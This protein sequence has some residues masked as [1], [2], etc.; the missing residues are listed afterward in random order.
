MIVRSPYPDVVIPVQPLTAFILA[1]AVDQG[2]LSSRID[3]ASGRALTYAQ[4]VADVRR[5]AIGLTERGLG[6]GDALAL[7][8]PNLPEYGYRTTIPW[9]F[10]LGKR[11]LHTSW[12]P[13]APC[14]ST[15]HPRAAFG[16]PC[17]RQVGGRVAVQPVAAQYRFL[18]FWAI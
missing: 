2:P 16:S 8:C 6:R 10:V 12:R 18:G 9:F 3:G 17:Q 4:L 13:C 15:G 1:N 11:L 14:L 5:L 7:Y